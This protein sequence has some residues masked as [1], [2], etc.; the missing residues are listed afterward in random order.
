ME[1]GHMLMKNGAQRKTVMSKKKIG[2]ALGGG[3]AR[4]IAHIGVLEVLEKEGIP[5]DLVAGI[6]AGAV[7]GAIYTSG[8]SPLRMKEFV[9]GFDWKL[10]RKL[11]DFSF[12]RS[13][14]MPGK[15]LVKTVQE[16]MGGNLKFN[17]LKKPFA[18]VASDLMT[19]EEVVMTTGTVAEAVHAS[20]AIPVVFQPVWR[21]G[22]YLIDGALMNSVPADVVKAM[23]ADYV[24]AVNV[25]PRRERKLK[26][27][28]EEKESPEDKRASRPNMVSIMLSVID[29][30]TSFKTE[31][32]LA[33]ADI[34]IEP[35][36]L[37]IG[38]GD[39]NKDKEAILQG[40]MA[41]AAAI[42]RIKR[43]IG[44]S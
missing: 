33:G 21:K 6:S 40:E 14:L 4:G 27:R 8:M 43:D 15:R 22:R 13:G 11:L 41:A 36:M 23:G 30:A 38:M 2:I 37:H 3:A 18:C 12:L 7:V 16:L 10:R 26:D 5:I 25:T 32:S 28:L 24:I 39:F 35:D 29:I 9:M 42:S 19:G 34:V 44:M 20:V 1:M 17:E 31:D